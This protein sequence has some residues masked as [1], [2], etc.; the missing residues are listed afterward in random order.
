MRR[1][2]ARAYAMQWLHEE[3]FQSKC[4]HVPHLEFAVAIEDQLKVY[5]NP[6]SGKTEYY[7]DGLGR[8][9]PDGGAHRVAGED[10]AIPLINAFTPHKLVYEEREGKT[11]VVPRPVK[12]DDSR[13]RNAPLAAP[14]CHDGEILKG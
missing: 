8:W 14:N 1:T 11:K 12:W 3:D 13:F 6:D 9:M 4:S 10:L 7:D 2:E 5:V